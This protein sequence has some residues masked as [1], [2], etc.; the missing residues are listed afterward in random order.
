MEYKKPLVVISR[1]LGF[2]HC[3]YDG[4]MINSDEVEKMKKYVDFYTICPEMEIGLPSPREAIRL[5]NKTG[6]DRLVFSRTGQDVTKDMADY[7]E[8]LTNRMVPKEPDGFLLKG[9][10]PSC[11]I[12]DVKV[13]KDIGKTP[14][15]NSKAIGMFGR[16]IM[17]NFEKE[18]FEDEG[19][20]TNFTLREHFYTV[21]FLR[22]QFKKIKKNKKMK[23]LVEFHSNNKYLFMAYSQIQLKALGKVVANHEKK[24][25]EEV[26]NLY[27][28]ILTRLLN[29]K[30]STGQYINVMLHIFGYFSNELS[31]KEKAHLLD[32]IEQ[33]RNKHIPQSTIMTIL[34]SWAIRFDMEYLINQTIFRPFPMEL[35]QVTDSGKGL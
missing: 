15:V 19:R 14:C 29:K 22:A 27:D 20:L 1:C 11:G 26:Y 9:R 28:D 35:I 2:D 7:V 4:S 12:K 13:Y 18:I 25:M 23:E 10:S 17:E 8:E 5:I 34:Y 30:P 3:R 32:L 6:E 21:I 33:Y 24:A 16:L 31:N